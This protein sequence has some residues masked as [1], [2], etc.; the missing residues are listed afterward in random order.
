MPDHNHLN[1]ERGGEVLEKYS[2]STRIFPS[3]EEISEYLLEYRKFLEKST[4]VP[5]VLEYD[6]SLLCS[7]PSTYLGQ[8]V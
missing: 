3:T 5:L 6:R 8:L 4:R 7:L 2:K 1:D